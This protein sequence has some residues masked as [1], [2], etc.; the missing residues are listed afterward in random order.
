MVQ[1]FGLWKCAYGGA[2]WRAMGGISRI[3]YLAEKRVLKE[4]GRVVNQKN[5]NE[6]RGFSTGLLSRAL[7]RQ[8][9][10]VPDT[11]L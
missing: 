4:K 8:P 2:A 6:L 3:V 9:K 7:E 5:Q 11:F 10:N 1:T